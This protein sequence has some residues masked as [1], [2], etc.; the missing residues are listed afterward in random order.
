[1]REEARTLAEQLV[2]ELSDFVVEISAKLGGY[3]AKAMSAGMLALIAEE[4]SIS[5][6]VLGAGVGKEGPGPLISYIAGKG[7]PVCGFP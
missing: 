4:P 7:A 1:M 3:R 6:L 5:I 2:A